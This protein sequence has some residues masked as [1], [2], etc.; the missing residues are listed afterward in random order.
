MNAKLLALGLAALIGVPAAM[1]Q[2]PW[3]G[4]IAG[5]YQGTLVSSG[6]TVPVSTQLNIGPGQTI[7]GSYTFIETGNVKVS[8]S[9][10]ACGAPRPQVLACKWRDKYGDGTLEMTFSG[11][12]RAFNGRWSASD[13]PGEWLAWSGRKG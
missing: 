4:T 8:G 5:Q 9:L 1:A 12:G 6:Q 7:R 2:A 11:D 3:T 13:E 10:E